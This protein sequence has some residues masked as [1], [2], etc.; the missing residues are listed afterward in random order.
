MVSY[1]F[2][3]TSALEKVFADR[4][5]EAIQP[6][7]EVLNNEKASFQIAYYV[8]YSGIEL[9]EDSIHFDIKTSCPCDV[10]VRKV[11]LMPGNLVCSGEHDNDYLKTTAGMFPDLLDEIPDSGIQAIHQ[12]WRSV[13]IDLIP[14][15]QTPADEHEVNIT[16]YDQD[17][18]PIWGSVLT[19]NVIGVR[20]PKMKFI[21]TEWFHADCIADYYKVEPFSE[22]HWTLLENFISYAAQHGINMILTPL[23]TPP[24]DTAIGGERTTVQL[25]DVAKDHNEYKFDFSK[26]DRWVE[27]ALRCG[28]EYLEMSPLFTQ[29]GAYHAPKIMATVDGAYERIFGWETDASG[30]EYR[31][32]LHRFLPALRVHL[33]SLNVWE[34][35][36]FHV[37]DEPNK[38]HMESYR[39][40]Q[41]CM[42]E[43]LCGAALFD[44]CSN[45]ELYLDGAVQRPIVCN[46]HIMPFIEKKVPNL[47]TYYCCVQGVDVSNRFF[48]MPSYRNRVIG[49]QAYLFGL[50]GF[51]HWG[52]NFYNS[53]CSRR[54]LDPY[55]VTDCDGSFPAG[56][57]FLVYPGDDGKP[58]G[59]IR[60]AV[61]EQAMNDI[62]AFEYLESLTNREHVEYLIRREAGET[63]TF[64]QYPRNQEFFHR[65][66]RAI[67]AEIIHATKN[68]P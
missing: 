3:L 13:W 4:K 5:P 32:F 8:D 11:C 1:R 22:K 66:R 53:R 30:S 40:A 24:M 39:S 9:F 56:D 26:L 51:L 65:L 17:G 37:S 34:R 59:S 68:M 23:F 19:L 25:I 15:E 7:L 48:A 18:K 35:A 14:V 10:K 6:Y 12:Q 54:H 41:K 2:L 20:L 64:A 45:L 31:E 16:V 62:R 63:I 29:W 21:H 33:Q 38:G 49:V 57:A 61:L 50:Q 28:M 60:L 43:D 27:T 55:A 46:D 36:W 42:N 52:Y 47:W 67:N 58:R 44:A